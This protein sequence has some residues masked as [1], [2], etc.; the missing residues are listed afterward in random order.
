MAERRTSPTAGKMGPA[1]AA[2]VGRP[3]AT[4]KAAAAAA[5]CERLMR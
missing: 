2:D 3:A 1:A 4:V 5:G